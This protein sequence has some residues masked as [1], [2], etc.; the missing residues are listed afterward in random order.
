MHFANRKFWKFYDRLPQNIQ[1][2]A[3][4][5]Y[6]LLKKNPAHPSLHFKK[7]SNQY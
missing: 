3:D 5:S 6:Q 2:L 4:E 1:A 7:I